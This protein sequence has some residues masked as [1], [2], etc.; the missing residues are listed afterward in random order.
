[1]GTT[2]VAMVVEELLRQRVNEIEFHIPF[3]PIETLTSEGPLTWTTNATKDPFDSAPEIETSRCFQSFAHSRV[4][5]LLHFRDVARLL[6]GD[7][8]KPVV[9][10]TKPCGKDKLL[11]DCIEEEALGLA[12]EANIVV[13]GLTALVTIEALDCDEAFK[14]ETNVEIYID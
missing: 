14:E 13:R 7:V 1:M 5:E 12:I 11:A 10:L 3:E 8:L 6:G 2:R 4:S 9:T